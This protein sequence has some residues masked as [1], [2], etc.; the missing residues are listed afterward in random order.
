MKK[1]KVMMTGFAVFAAVLM[2]MATCMAKPVQEKASIEAVEFAEKELMNSFE[3]LNVKLS[4]DAESRVLLDAIARDPD[5]ARIVNRMGTARSEEEIL[6]GLEQLAVVLQDSS[7]FEQ[8]AT[9]AGEEY[10]AELGAISEELLSSMGYDTC[11]IID[12][13][14]GIIT[15]IIIILIVIGI[16]I[17]DIIV[18]IGFIIGRIISILVW[19]W[20]LITGDGDGDGGVTA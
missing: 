5:V 15:T 4:R 16:I 6:S 10:S 1:T 13:L 19:L 12:D 7:E 9:L 20:G 17:Y 11:S 14:I 18:I 8:L 2:L 3:A